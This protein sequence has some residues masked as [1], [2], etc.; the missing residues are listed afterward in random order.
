VIR[1]DQR[2]VL[3]WPFTL[4]RKSL[5]WRAAPLGCAYAEYSAPLVEDGPEAE[6]RIRLAWQVLRE[7]TGCDVIA[8]PHVWHGSPFDKL[9]AGEDVTITSKVTSLRVNWDGHEDWDHFYRSLKRKDQRDTQRRRR[10][11]DEQGKVSF[12]VV[13]GAA[14][15]PLIDWALR[16]KIEQLARTGKRAPWLSDGAYR[17]LLG[18]AASRTGPGGGIIIFVLKLADNIIA[19]LICRVDKIRV[20]ALNTVYDHAYSK[21]APGK[22][23][24]ELSL[25]WACQHRLELD[26][27]GGD[28]PYKRLWANRESYVTSYEIVNSRRYALY[29]RWRKLRGAFVECAS[30]GAMRTLI[31]ARHIA[32]R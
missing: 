22:I 29:L 31:S 6:R 7:T 1:E 25:K 2:V 19:T 11:L 18:R 27:R 17:E 9:M 3:I 13:E 26:M 21:Y 20:E 30:R 8:I 23:L 14:C 12:D 5:F 10:R 24:W 4:F 28:F 32:T 15:V 16:N